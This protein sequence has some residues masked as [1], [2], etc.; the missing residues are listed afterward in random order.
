MFSKDHIQGRHGRF[1]AVSKSSQGPSL[2]S[3][4]GPDYDFMFNANMVHILP[5][6]CTE[7]LFANARDLFFLTDVTHY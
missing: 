6:K 1:L 3:Q 7:T 4:S 2:A 5:W